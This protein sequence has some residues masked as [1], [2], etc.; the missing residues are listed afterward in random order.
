MAIPKSGFDLSAKNLS[1][2]G[3]DAD[4][5]LNRQPKL[6]KRLFSELTQM[7]EDKQFKPLSYRLFESGDIVEAFRLMQQSGHIGKIVIKAPEHQLVENVI[8]NEEFTADGKGV[9]I[10]IGGPWRFWTGSCP[11]ACRPWS[12][13]HRP[14]QP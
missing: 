14:H 13:L 11:L 8:A 12:A 7:F 4:Q 9:H 3:I 6:S 10:I 5:L 2:F 1:Y